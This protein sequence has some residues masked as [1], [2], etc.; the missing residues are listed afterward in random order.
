[1]RKKT[2]LVLQKSLDD[3][4]SVFS[5]KSNKDYGLIDLAS[6]T[7]DN[8]FL[9]DVSAPR[10]LYSLLLMPQVEEVAS[11]LANRVLLR[12]QAEADRI[13]SMQTLE[14]LIDC[15]KNRPDPLNHTKVVSRLLAHGRSAADS[16][17]IAMQMPVN[18][19]FIELGARVLYKFLP[20]INCEILQLI[21]H[22]PRRAYQVSLLSILLGFAGQLHDGQFLWDYYHLFRQLFPEETYS[23]GPLLGLLEYRRRFR[24]ELAADIPDYVEKLLYSRT[25]SRM[26]EP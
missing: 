17:L 12:G 19:T 24:P 14:K 15:A 7:I 22:G 23:D 4:D 20:E 13:D 11:S 16:I 10:M 21:Q 2:D 6:P 25:T 5:P 3:G 9:H 1:M 18:A 26:T 8:K